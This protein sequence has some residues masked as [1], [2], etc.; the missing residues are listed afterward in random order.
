MAL[1]KL[2]VK[3]TAPP[4]ESGDIPVIDVIGHQVA[5]YNKAS[6]Q[7]KEAEARMEELSE[8]LTKAGLGEIYAR[9]IARP[10]TPTLTV[11]LRDEEK[12]VL[13][14][15]FTRKYSSVKA[16]ER[17]EALFSSR[18]VDINLYVQ[19]AVKATFDDKVFYNEDGDF[20]QETYEAYRKAIEQVAKR[21]G[22]NCP[23]QTGKVV[24]VKPT[25]HTE[26]FVQFPNEEDQEVLTAC[27]PNT[28]RIVP[29]TVNKGP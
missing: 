22:Q 9:S 5:D 26:R 23:L 16:I 28:T 12:E 24:S 7:A 21:L 1:K 3:L 14:V 10:L 11:K 27:M 17:A 4:A 20:N 15:E 2:Q 18:K 29:V 6:A 13:R 25:F 19:E 8:S